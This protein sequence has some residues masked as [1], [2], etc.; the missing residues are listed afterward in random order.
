MSTDWFATN[1]KT[2]E[3]IDIDLASVRDG[4][5][6]NKVFLSELAGMIGCTGTGSEKVLS[7]LFENK[8]NKNE[9]QGTQREIA[10]KTDVGSATVTRVIKRLKESG[11]IKLRRSGMY[12]INP[13]VVYYG[14]EGNRM[15]VLKVWNGLK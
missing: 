15:A 12:I 5:S 4:G 6:F 2:G 11:Y 9:V 8:N 1:R 10:E 14:K 7:W 3:V 13:S